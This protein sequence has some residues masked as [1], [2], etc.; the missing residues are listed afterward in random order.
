MP[1]RPPEPLPSCPLLDYDRAPT[2][3]DSASKAIAMSTLAFALFDRGLPGLT[4]GLA[5]A[6]R[7][8]LRLLYRKAFVLLALP[9]FVWA[10]FST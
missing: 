2:E 9:G 7:L 10:A 8:A 6:H 3:D 5:G 1:P 4:L